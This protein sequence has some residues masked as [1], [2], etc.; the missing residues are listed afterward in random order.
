MHDEPIQTD[1]AHR[2]DHAP[3]HRRGGLGAMHLL[4]AANMLAL[5]FLGFVKLSASA[6]AQVRPRSTYTAASGR[7][8]GTEVHA[9]YIVDEVTQELIAVQWDPQK[10]QLR[11][12][13]YRNLVLD[14]SD[15]SRPRAN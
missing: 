10:K 4:V 1:R 2:S 11:G 5:G 9:L 6:E 7:I 14:A 13:G 8:Q 15:S 3:A 12:L